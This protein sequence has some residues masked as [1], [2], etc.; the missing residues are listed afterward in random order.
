MSRPPAGPPSRSRPARTAPGPARRTRPPA[1]R[2]PRRSRP[3]TSARPPAP[4]VRA[5]RGRAGADAARP[6]R[7]RPPAPRRP[8]AARARGPARARPRPPACRRSRSPASEPRLEGALP[9]HATGRYRPRGRPH[10]VPVSSRIARNPAPVARCAGTFVLPRL[11]GRDRRGHGEVEHPAASRRQQDAGERVVRVSKQQL[12]IAMAAAIR[13]PRPGSTYPGADRE[14][15]HELL[16]AGATSEH[17]H[18]V[19]ARAAPA[20]ASD[21]LLVLGG[22]FARD[23][24]G[25][26]QERADRARRALPPLRANRRDGGERRGASR[27]RGG[28]AELTRPLRVASG[29]GATADGGRRLIGASP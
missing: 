21:D 22:A 24:A 28:Q 26:G 18:L 8:V 19:A 6:S 10:A 2:G 12:S 14:S 4:A 1:A 7:R 9:A 20:V 25:G 11:G 23:L 5:T 16:Q 15:L 29:H 3:Q 13:A 27:V 17:G